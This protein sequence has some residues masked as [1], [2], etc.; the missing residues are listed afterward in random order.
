MRRY[1]FIRSAL[2]LLVAAT[3]SPLMPD[4]AEAC[5]RRCR[6]YT[7]D[8]GRGGFNE[9][10]RSNTEAARRESPG[11][12]GGRSDGGNSDA[13]SGITDDS[14]AKRLQRMEEQLDRIEKKLGTGG[15]GSNSSPATPINPRRQAEERFLGIV[16]DL[17]G[18]AIDLALKR[19]GLSL[20]M[21]TAAMQRETAA[22]AKKVAAPDVPQTGTESDP[23]TLAS[24]MAKLDEIQKSQAEA[25]KWQVEV[26]TRLKTLESKK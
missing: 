18:I 25:K 23:A 5:R 26:D 3:M 14:V 21:E 24:V 8:S 10:G 17:G 12:T 9:S 11:S 20:A 16:E 15:T 13:G 19:L 22:V 2:I 6:C 7:M 1:H 4:S